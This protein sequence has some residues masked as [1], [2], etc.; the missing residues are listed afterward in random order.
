MKSHKN[1]NDELIPPKLKKPD[2]CR[3]LME[4]WKTLLSSWRQEMLEPYKICR[5]LTK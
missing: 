3:S 4:K 2:N 1:Q 5:K